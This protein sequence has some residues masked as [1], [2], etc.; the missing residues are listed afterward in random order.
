MPFPVGSPPGPAILTQPVPESRSAP[1]GPA[2]QVLE[3]QPPVSLVG[4]HFDETVAAG[5]LTPQQ[6]VANEFFTAFNAAD[7]QAMGKAYA[8][9][10]KFADPIYELDGA[11]AIGHMW[12]SLLEK[13]KNLRVT[14]EFWPAEPGD[15]P[16]V[17]R[18][19]WKADYELFGRAVHNESASKLIIKDGKIV[20]HQDDWSWKN[21]AAQAMPAPI[22][23]LAQFTPVKQLVIFFLNRI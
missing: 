1:Q 12:S 10:A 14:S 18:V 11:K 17:V 2:N 5:V 19:R 9:T 7:A 23:F 20:S 6:K 8:D 4:S 15:G 22:G 21:W 3:K 13:G 16:D